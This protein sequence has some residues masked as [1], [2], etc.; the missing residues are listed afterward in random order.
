MT[1]RPHVSNYMPQP[2]YLAYRGDPIDR[3]PGGDDL[4]AELTEAIDKRLSVYGEAVH[5]LA[6][7]VV[8]QFDRLDPDGGG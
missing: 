6:N 8:E 7:E 3:L 1:V 4:L 2:K 5:D